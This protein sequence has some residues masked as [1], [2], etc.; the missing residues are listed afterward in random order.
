MTVDVSSLIAAIDPALVTAAILG[1]GAVLVVPR[2]ARMAVGWVKYQVGGYDGDFEDEYS[3]DAPKTLNDE[4]YLELQG[5]YSATFDFRNPDRP[6]FA[7]W[8]E[9]KGYDVDQYYSRNE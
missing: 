6:L 8:L 4:N 3:Y 1:V 5:V 2:L 7:D 9:E